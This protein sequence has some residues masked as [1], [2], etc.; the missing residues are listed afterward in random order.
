MYVYIYLFIFGLTENSLPGDFG[1]D[2][3]M[4]IDFIQMSV[5]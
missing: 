5:N 1:S 3:K 4:N 2:V